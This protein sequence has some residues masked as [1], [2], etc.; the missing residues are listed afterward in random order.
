MIDVPVWIVKTWT[1]EILLWTE[2]P[3]KLLLYSFIWTFSNCVSSDS[4][5]TLR[6]ETEER[7][8]EV[9]IRDTKILSSSVKVR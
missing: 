5:L 6:I 1:E 4:H 2:Y 9:Q 3:T 8:K 7:V